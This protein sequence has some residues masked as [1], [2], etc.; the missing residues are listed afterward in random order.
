MSPIHP[1][2]IYQS[3]STI[4]AYAQ[5][6]TADK[7]L[8]SSAVRELL[9]LV[10]SRLGK[11]SVLSDDNF[12]YRLMVGSLAQ[13]FVSFSHSAD[14]VALI[15][16]PYPCGVDV[17]KRAI[18]QAVAKRFF[19]HHEN[20]Y[21]QNYPA[22]TQ[23]IYRQIL[24]QLKESWIKLNGGTLT[25]GMGVDFG[26]YLAHIHPQNDSIIPLHDGYMTYI[27]PSLHLSAIFQMD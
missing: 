25:Q 27:N 20:L 18:T 22:D 16:S 13:E 4:I 19:S 1:P 26:Q 11:Q 14:C 8:Q 15:I 5:M 3:Q 6:T 17:E 9:H 24:W 10:L 2:W 23:A 7:S 21:L 12:P